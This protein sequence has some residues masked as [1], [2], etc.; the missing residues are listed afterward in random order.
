MTDGRK[1][2]LKRVYLVYAGIILLGIAIVLK[3]IYIQV[4]EGPELIQK[5]QEQE[6]RYFTIEA[7]RG[8]IMSSDGSMMA[9]S[10]PIFE[11]RMD[12]ASPLISKQMF[13]QKVDSLAAA[14]AGLFGDKSKFEYKSSLIKAREKGN[15]YFLIKKNVTYTQLKQLREFPIFR[16]GKY[17]GG[18]IT[19]SYTRRAM[20]FGNL[21]RRTIGFEVKEEGIFVGLEGSYSE[22]LAGRNG[23]QLHRKLSHGDWMPVQDENQVEPENG[24]DIITTIDIN[25]QDIAESALME[26]LIKNQAFQGCAVVMEVETG[27]IKAIAN[28]RLNEK[29]GKYEELYNYA[30]GEIAEPGSTFKLA[31]I[32]ALLEDKKVKLTDIVDVGDGWTTYYGHTVQDVKK[33]GDGKITVREA[34]EKSS[35][36]GISKLIEKAYSD[37]P[38]QFVAHLKNMHLHEPLGVE[39]KGEGIPVVKDPSDKKNWY[40]T[41]LPV[42]SYGY[43][44]MMTPLQILT[45]YNAIANNG[46]M[47]KPMFVKEIKSSGKT[48]EKFRTEILDNRICS[49]RTVDSVKSL[50][51]GV[52]ER[53]TATII[54]NAPYKIAGKTGT[55][56]IA[57]KNKGYGN[58]VYNSSFVGYFPANDPKYSC[59]VLVND[60]R[61]GYYYGSSV[62]APVFR[63]I[64]DKIYASAMLPV[65]DNDTGDLAQPAY[66]IGLHNDLDEIFS[67]LGIEIDTASRHTEWIVAKG[68]KHNIKYLPR[69]VIPGIVPNVKGMKAR[70]AVYLLE[71][72]GLKTQ[73]QGR[74]VVTEQSIPSGNRI[75]KG[76]TIT[77]KLST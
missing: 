34:F 15:R 12:V 33:I 26:N 50:L 14:L 8:N 63:E 43:E 48:I 52:V 17:K 6:L 38:K 59:I 36:V 25:Y 32:I 27:E 23:V 41:T 69:R 13:S 1:T 3:V 24:K 73:I 76:R 4:A 77:L 30:I 75:E 58:K 74:G 35:N 53:G 10:V 16:N 61:K 5:A 54:R 49:R 72:L 55:A 47:V 18:I 31:S 64:A 2:I 7:N 20:P 44:V 37:N 21:A 28:L 29:N 68:Q 40:G 67:Q 65:E 56:R 11:V 62:A 70:D 42:M 45:F 19:R 66:A 46:T 57:D 39:I 60:P 71:N 51:E 22:F 9:V